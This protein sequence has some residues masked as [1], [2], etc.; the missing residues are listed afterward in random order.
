MTILKGAG[1]F[2]VEAKDGAEAIKKVA[3]SNDRFDIVITDIVMPHIDGREL[4]DKLLEAMPDLRILYISGYDNSSSLPLIAK[5]T[6]SD[7]L[8]KPFTAA[9]LTRKVRELLDL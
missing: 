4:A 9:L 2:A 6:R 7:F 8:Q 3:L 5:N 1:Y